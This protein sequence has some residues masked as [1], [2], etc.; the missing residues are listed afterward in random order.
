M[1]DWAHAVLYACDEI[2]QRR[3]STGYSPQIVWQADAE[4][5]LCAAVLVKIQ[6]AEGFLHRIAFGR[7]VGIAFVNQ[8]DRGVIDADAGALTGRGNLR[9]I[10]LAERCGIRRLPVDAH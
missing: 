10:L 3:K 8:F 1:D 5:C 7:V 4:L 6:V 9:G 2:L